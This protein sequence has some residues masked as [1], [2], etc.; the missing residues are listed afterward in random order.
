M[1][2]RRCSSGSR[3]AILVGLSMGG[4]IAQR[5]ALEHPRRIVGLVLVGATP[6]GLGPDVQVANVLAAI[7]ELGVEQASQRVIE[8]SFGPRRGSS[9]SSPSERSSRLRRLSRNGRSCR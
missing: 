6:H 3:D 5:F 8:R 9:S 1:T 4:T 2:W 7:D